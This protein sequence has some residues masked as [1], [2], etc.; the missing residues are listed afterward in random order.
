MKNELMETNNT[1]FLALQDFDLANVMSEEMDGLSATFEC[2]KIPSG[3]GIMFEIPGDNP[4]EPETVKEFSAVILY[5]HS[6]NAYYK[7]EY[8]GGSNPPDC[9]N[10]DGHNGEVIPAAIVITVRLIS[11]V[12]AKTV[13][14]PARTAVVCICFVR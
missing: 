3:G 1:G 7:S 6:L 2:V 4:D 11:T 12:Q 13:R 14:K 8:Q 10:F 5:Q 9:G